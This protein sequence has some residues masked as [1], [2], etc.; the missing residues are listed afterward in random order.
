VAWKAPSRP[1][2]SDAQPRRPV[3]LAA[4]S[5]I[6]AVNVRPPSVDRDSTILG[7]AGG[8]AAPIH[9]TAMVRVPPADA[10]ATRGG[11]SALVTAP[12]GVGL[13]RTG[14]PKAAPPSA[15]TAA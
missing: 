4:D 1:A 7:P 6:G 9:S 5:A 12:P 8:L 14:G 3:A 11:R 2:A 13:T 15:L 10:N